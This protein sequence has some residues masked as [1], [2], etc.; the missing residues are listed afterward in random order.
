VWDVARGDRRPVDAGLCCP[1]DVAMMQAADFGNREDHAEF[2]RLD[3]PSVRR[4]LV[5][6]E[7]SSCGVIVG[8]I[9]GQNASQMPLAENDDMI[10]TLAPA[11]PMSRSTNGLCHRLWGAVSTSRIPMPFTRPGTGD[12]RPCRDRR[13]DRTAPSLPGGVDDLLGDPCRGGM[14]GH[15]EVEDATAMV[16]E[17]LPHEPHRGQEFCKSRSSPV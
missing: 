10:Q 14:L 13:G 1:P 9:R 15:V 12:C 5:E 8:E 7:V 4:V 17:L 16:G 11:E 2:R 3:W 6:R